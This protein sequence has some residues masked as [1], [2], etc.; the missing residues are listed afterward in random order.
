MARRVLLVPLLGLALASGL[1]AR[2]ATA[3]HVTVAPDAPAPWAGGTALV[4]PLEAIASRIA[5]HI[6]GHRVSVRCETEATFRR[7]AGNSD[8][9]GLVGSVVDP[10][11]NRYLRDSTVIELPSL[12][13]GPLQRFAQARIKPT[14]CTPKGSSAS[15]PC[16]IGTPQKAG[17]AGTYLCW[18]KT[19]FAVGT[20]RRS[21]W[22]AYNAYA[23]SIWALAHEAIHT[24]QARKGALQPSDSVIEVQ[25]DCYGMQWVP[26]V[27]TR[28]GASAADAR[29]IA[30]YVW[31]GDY[32][33]QKVYAHTARPYWSPDCRPGGRLDIRPSG[34]TFW[35]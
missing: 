29:A 35:P 4:T 22:S 2:A 25:A 18:K 23:T 11:T 26:D 16:F 9:R 15:I 12:T 3:D 21:Y 17:S 5:S 7:H 34:A 13:C 8:L 31:L 24:Q 33:Q 19:C 14:R 30:T 28:L 20:A 10:R 32:P 27:A 6:A 1:A